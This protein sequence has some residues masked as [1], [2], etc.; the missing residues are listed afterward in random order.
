MNLPEHFEIHNLF[1]N[2]VTEYQSYD[3]QLR[4]IAKLPFT[5]LSPLALEPNFKQAGIYLITGGRQVGKTTFIKQYIL[6]LLEQDHISPENILFLPG[7]LIDSH[8]ILIRMV[9]SFIKPNALNYLFID[10][11]NYIPEWDKGIKYLADAGFLEN[12]VVML[13]GSDSLILR[14]AMQR[15]AGRRGIVDKVDYIFYPLSFKEF[16]LIK[17]PDFHALCESIQAKPIEAAN[18]L[19]AKSHPELIILLNQYLVHGGYLPAIADDWQRQTIEPGTLRTYI[20]WIVGDMLK[21]KKSEKHVFEILKGIL[22]TY[23]SQISWNNLLKHLSIEHHQTVAD[24]CHILQDIHVIYILEALNENTR[25]AAPKKNKKLYFQ[26]PFIYHAASAFIH[27]DLSYE[28][29]KHT[30]QNPEKISQLIEGIVISHC[31]RHHKTYYIK[32]NRGEVDVAFID[33][34]NFFPIEIKWTSQLRSEDLKQ[35][36]SY[37]N[38]MILWNRPNEQIFQNIPVIPL[39]KFLLKI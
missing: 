36:Q 39:P 1:K 20:E 29:I 6:Q 34:N 4:R 38:G 10:E 23:S 22:T 7:E 26:D 16:V 32:G 28:C 30:L 17:N 33:K 11:I 13:T 15:F 27:Q 25:M 31:K 19:Y 3:P 24:Y 21:A 37:S 35:I 5:Y 2:S 12:T 8:H 9:E 18:E 14:T